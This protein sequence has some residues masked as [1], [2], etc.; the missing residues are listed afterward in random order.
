MIDLTKLTER[1]LQSHPFN[2]A[3]IS[4]LYS[5]HDAVALAKTFPHDY[6]KTV[7][8]YGGEKDY[9]YE[10]RQLVEMGTHR[11]INPQTLSPEW[12]GLAQDLCL[13]SYRSAMSLLT[14]IDLISAPI[15]VNVFHYGPGAC[16]GPHPDLSD[17]LVTHILY[18]NESWNPNDGGCLNILRSPDP[19]GVV[20]VV[21]PIVGNSAIVVRSDDSWHAVS[22]V[23]DGCLSSRRSVTVTFYRPSSVS[24]MW[25]ENDQ[26]PLHRYD[27]D[28][29]ARRRAF[30]VENANG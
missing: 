8:G 3:E 1:R 14:G 23:V 13:P 16:L 10:A 15:E 30:K 28:V 19:G 24:S 17:K 29:E 25:P 22:R 27:A 7:S 12:L 9:E 20:A 6:F 21:P 5:L 11:I 2:W 26:S 4:D 18:F